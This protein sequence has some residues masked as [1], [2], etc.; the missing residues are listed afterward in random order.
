MGDYRELMRKAGLVIAALGMIGCAQAA[1]PGWST[2][3]D[4]KRG[5]SISY[6]SD[7]KVNPAFVDKGYRFFQGE[8]DDTRDG[9]AF[10]PTT[11]IAPG[12]TLQSNQLVLAVERARAGDACTA[13]AFLTDPPPDYFT[14]RI[15][16]KPEAVQTVAEA[17]DLYN[18]EH[19]VVMASRSPC[20]AVQ[21]TLIYSRNSRGD[22]DAPKPFDR[23]AVIGLLNKI[24]STLKPN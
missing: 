18:I 2:Y 20:I 12:T 5:F 9:I 6:P 16:D 10:S 3:T 1:E 17:G 11:D 21:Y 7:W 4:A 15:V 8:T 24:A 13:A 14:Q 23:T 19:I 22:P